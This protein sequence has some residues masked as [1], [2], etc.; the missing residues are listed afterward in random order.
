MGQDVWKEKRR[1]GRGCKRLFLSLPAPAPEKAASSPH[2][3]PLVP[4]LEGASPETG[5]GSPLGAISDLSLGPRLAQSLI[6]EK[7][8]WLLFVC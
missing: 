2:S 1:T 5:G 8:L 7:C 6:W 4:H 3:L